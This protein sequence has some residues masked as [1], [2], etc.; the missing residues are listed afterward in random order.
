MTKSNT[1]HRKLL[2][3]SMSPNQKLKQVFFRPKWGHINFIVIEQKIVKAL[4]LRSMRMLARPHTFISDYF[5]EKTFWSRKRRTRT[6][7]KLSRWTFQIFP[8]ISRYF[9]PPSHSS[10]VL[11]GYLRLYREA[12]KR[13]DWTEETSRVSLEKTWLR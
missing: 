11:R 9:C 4:R 2:H 5:P 6:P 10:S 3:Q 8:D 13:S 7:T 1:R 12:E